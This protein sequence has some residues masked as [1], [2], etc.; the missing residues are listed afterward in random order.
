[1]RAASIA[2][3]C[4]I[5]RRLVEAEP[6]IDAFEWR[7]RIKRALVAQR[8][9]YPQPHVLSDAMDRVERVLGGR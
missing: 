7:E 2:Q 6:A 4:A 3:L 1:M 9:R 5:A 8:L